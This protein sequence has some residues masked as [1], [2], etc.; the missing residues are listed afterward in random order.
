MS[1]I[2]DYLLEIIDAHSDRINEAI[3]IQKRVWDGATGTAA[4]DATDA[5]RGTANTAAGATGTAV[6]DAVGGEP[7]VHPLLLTRGDNMFASA[8]GDYSR[9]GM[10]SPFHPLPAYNPKEIHYDS[11]K[12]FV[13]ELIGAARAAAGGMQAVPSV[14]ANMGCG[15]FPTLFGI[16]QDLFEDKMPWVQKHLSKDAIMKMGPEDLVFSDEFKSGLE[17]MDYMAEKLK[18]SCC[19]LY[20]MDLQGPF[21][22]AHLVYGDAIFYD[23]YDDPAF[24]RHLMELS[25]EAIFMGME[26]CVRHIP[27]AADGFRHYNNLFMPNGKGGIK[28]SEDTSTLLSEAHIREF[29][30]PY[31]SKV[32]ERYNGGY[33]HY[34]GKNPHLFRAFMDLPL[35]Y[36]INFGNPDMHNMAA[37]LKECADRNKIY[38]GTIPR[39]G[40]ET[41]VGYFKRT[42][43][44]ATYNGKTHLLLS[45]QTDG[46][47]SENPEAIAEAWNMA[48]EAV[49]VMRNTHTC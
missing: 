36:G 2:I 44:D 12:M 26:E 48:Y 47:G 3:N 11:E 31:T 37:V 45:Y 29:V 7:Y 41:Q 17:H 46:E 10:D 35:A 25:C 22:T 4:G 20:P 13:S 21:D 43:A 19:G 28:I 15:I 6:G 40:G 33:I 42:L 1:G 18:G 32:L 34:C 5:G 16:E 24:I 27:D 14:R 9:A 8:F 30:A 39:D 38:Y 23:L 49:T